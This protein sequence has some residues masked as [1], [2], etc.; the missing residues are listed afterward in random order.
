MGLAGVREP[1][2]VL[3]GVSAW[4]CGDLGNVL[5]IFQ[6]AW[7]ASICGYKVVERNIVF[8]SAPGSSAVRAAV[9]LAD[10]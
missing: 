8:S 2:C 5:L 3:W 1:L 4:L 10:L 9:S 6:H 7:A